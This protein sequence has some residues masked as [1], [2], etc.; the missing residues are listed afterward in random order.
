MK[1]SWP[2]PKP[3][4]MGGALGSAPK[5]LGYKK[6]FNSKGS[7][8]G[9][10]RKPQRWEVPRVRPQDGLVT[11]GTL[12]ANEAFLAT[13]KTPEMGGPLGSAPQNGLF[14]RGTLVAN[15]ASLATPKTLGM[16]GPLGSAP[17]WPVYKRNF[18]R[19]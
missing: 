13:P 5:W 15:E 17:K 18:S 14:T 9:H 2:P 3:P 10:L 1:H 4:E 11:R 7:I 6:T 8:P 12:I 19:T 16:G